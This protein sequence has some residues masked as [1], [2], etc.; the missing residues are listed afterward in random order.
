MALSYIELDTRE[1]AHGE[2]LPVGMAEAGRWIGRDVR[3]A[4]DL[5]LD[6]EGK[7]DLCELKY[8]N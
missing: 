7:V 8:N 1:L 2:N 5:L 6:E 3:A 4:L